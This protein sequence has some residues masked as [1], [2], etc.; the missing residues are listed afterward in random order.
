MG[1]VEDE[2]AVLTWF[3]V[4]RKTLKT[5]TT[6]R[7]LREKLL[8]ALSLSLWIWGLNQGTRSNIAT[9]DR[10]PKQMDVG[11]YVK[12]LFSRPGY[13]PPI[14]IHRLDFRSLRTLLPY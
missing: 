6:S 10:G 7:V 8:R 2:L 5:D 12:I 9:V 14:V 11:V 13:D 3:A 4:T 1:L